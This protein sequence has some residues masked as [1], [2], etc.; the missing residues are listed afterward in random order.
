MFPGVFDGGGRSSEFFLASNR[1]TLT[2]RTA[3]VAR[4]LRFSGRDSA[5]PSF[6]ASQNCATGQSKHC[7]AWGAH[8]VAPSSI[9]DWFQSPGDSLAS[10]RSAVACNSRQRFGSRRSP[11]M[12]SRREMTRAT[13]PSSTAYLS[14]QAM[15]RIAAAVYSPMPARVRM[16]SR[17]RGNSPPNSATIRCAAFCKFR[18][19]L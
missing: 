18:A 10:M 11:R 17:R 16:S 19:R 9:M 1:T 13:L 6:L 4:F 7:G 8:T 15:L 3:T 12:A 14:L 2:S 5:T